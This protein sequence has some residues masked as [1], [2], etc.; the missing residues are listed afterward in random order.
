MPAGALAGPGREK[1]ALMSSLRAGDS[2][3]MVTA[4]RLTLGGG[5]SWKSSSV[6]CRDGLLVRLLTSVRANCLYAKLDSVSLSRQQ[7]YT[8]SRKKEAM[9]DPR[10]QRRRPHLMGHIMVMCSFVGSVPPEPSEPR[11]LA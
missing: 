5:A 11:P 8:R 7:K 4:S 2:F 3:D 6:E 1:G 9:V 10:S